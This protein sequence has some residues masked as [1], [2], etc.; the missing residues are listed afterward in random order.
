VPETVEMR[1]P[2]VRIGNARDHLH[3]VPV[4]LPVGDELEAE[5]PVEGHRTIHVGDAQREM[6]DARDHGPP[7]PVLCQ[8]L[9]PRVHTLRRP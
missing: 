4:D 9:L 1:D 7:L 3:V 6:V 8:V 5:L 2:H